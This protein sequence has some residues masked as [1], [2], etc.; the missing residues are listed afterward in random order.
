MDNGG[1]TRGGIVV[2]YRFIGL[3]VDRRGA[4]NSV[5]FEAVESCCWVCSGPAGTES[6]V[7]V[8]GFTGLSV[9]VSRSAAAVLLLF[10]AA[11][12]NTA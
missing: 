6:N 5:K 4:S 11:S 9:A 10:T 12:P 7:I 3:D 1:G 8:T 2:Q